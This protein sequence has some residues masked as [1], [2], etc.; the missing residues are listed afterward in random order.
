ME[1]MAKALPLI[2]AAAL[3][4]I[5]VKASAEGASEYSQVPN[6]SGKSTI[7][8][9][10]NEIRQPQK[11]ATRVFPSERPDYKGLEISYDFYDDFTFCES[12]NPTTRFSIR[13]FYDVDND[14][15]WG[16]KEQKMVEAEI[17]MYMGNSFDDVLRSVYGDLLTDYQRK[18][19][20]LETSKAQGKLETAVTGNETSKTEKTIEDLYPEGKLDKPEPIFQKYPVGLDEKNLAKLAK[21][22]AKPQIKELTEK[23]KRRHGLR[24]TKGWEYGLTLAEKLMLSEFNTKEGKRIPAPETAIQTT[25]DYAK[26]N[27][28]AKPVEQYKPSK[29]ELQLEIVTGPGHSG[30]DNGNLLDSI[31]GFIGGKVGLVGK[32]NDWLKLGGAINGAY[33]LPETVSS[34]QTEPSATGRYFVGSIENGK[35]AGLGADV[36][37]YLGKNDTGTYFLFGIGPNVWV[38]EQLD[39]IKLM[40]SRNEEMSSNSEKNIIY[41]PSIEAYLGLQAKWLKLTGGWD[42]RKGI[43]GGIG[44]VIPLSK[45]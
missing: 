44:G 21:E 13:S 11:I 2:L 22:Y 28:E 9:P 30:I 19:K 1:S 26:Q 27:K 38:Y 15:N 41:K 29:L 7:I 10:Q 39:S 17:P 3:T 18:I 16:L 6:D 36:E 35:M 37:F 45:E 24:D 31:P 20:D 32:V 12:T 4:A 34:F 40:N 8:A 33:G 14:K 43:F 5:G 25:E 42:S 23:E